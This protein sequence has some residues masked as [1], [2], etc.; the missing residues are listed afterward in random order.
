MIKMYFTLFFL[1][2][3]RWRPKYE[4]IWFVNDW[5]LINEN[6]SQFSS[7]E[8]NIFRISKSNR[9]RLQTAYWVRRTLFISRTL[10]LRSALVWDFTQ[11]GMVDY[12]STLLRKIPE[13]NRSHLH[14]GGKLKSCIL[15]CFVMSSFSIIGFLMWIFSFRNPHKKSTPEISG[16]CWLLPW[17]YYD[18]S[19]MDLPL[20]G[21]TVLH[22][23]NFTCHL[24]PLFYELPLE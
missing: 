6:L 12:H 10:F 23:N 3:Y 18:I 2:W 1:I 19:K 8:A 16:P 24:S 13:E 17:I 20:F 7:R 4:Y 15:I 21:V 14:S 5:F 22:S 9:Y 11:R